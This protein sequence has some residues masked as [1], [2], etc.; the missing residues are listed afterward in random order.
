MTL[1]RPRHGAV[2]CA[3]EPAFAPDRRQPV[4]VAPAAV[5]PVTVKPA[6][7][8]PVTVEPVAVVTV[9][10]EP[11]ATGPV[12]AEP[13][14]VPSLIETMRVESG[15]A[16]PLLDLHLQRVQRSCDALGHVWPGEAAIRKRLSQILPTLDSARIWRARLLLSPNGAFEVEHSPLERL[17]EPVSVIV[18][19]PR[20]GGAA[21]W[22]RHKTTHRPWYVQATQWLAEHPD[23]FDVLY[24]NDEGDMCEGS[25][26]NLYMQ[27]ADGRWLTPPLATG[28]LPGVQRQALL[29]AGLAHEAAISR[30][31]FLNARAWRISNALRGWL[32]ARPVSGQ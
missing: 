21:T 2:K 26:S 1:P 22:L 8:E 18:T 4:D 15:G 31:E 13:A 19:G 29:Q 7:V 17:A 28:A 5:E 9:A 14:A 12:A 27:A 30:D 32:D 16:M 3:P 25:R 24:W 10:I 23:V 11:V 6:T 20:Q